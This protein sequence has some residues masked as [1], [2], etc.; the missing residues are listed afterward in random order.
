MS[1]YDDKVEKQR[2]LLEAEEWANGINLVHIHSLKSMWYDDRPQDTDTGNVTD[3]QFN[4]G[5]ITREKSGKLL[6]T[7]NNEQVT[8]D[9]LI[10]RYMAGLK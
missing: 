8:G 4:D 10:S 5:R 7:W 2:L 9:D 3:T 6:H 1:Q